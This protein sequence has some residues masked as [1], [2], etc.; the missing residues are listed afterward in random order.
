M[1][2]QIQDIRANDTVDRLAKMA[3]LLPLPPPPPPLLAGF[4]GRNNLLWEI[5]YFKC[6]RNFPLK[7]QATVRNCAKPGAKF[8]HWGASPGASRPARPGQPGERE[9][10]IHPWPWWALL[11]C[12][13]GGRR[14]RPPWRSPGAAELSRACGAAC[15]GDCPCIKPHSTPCFISRECLMNQGSGSRIKGSQ[16][17]EGIGVCCAPKPIKGRVLDCLVPCSSVCL[18]PKADKGASVLKNT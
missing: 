9:A 15:V 16:M 10:F 2:Q 1:L 4:P 13:L 12:C 18:C 11:D 14:V 5:S 8:S 6:V 7:F 3:A 17:N